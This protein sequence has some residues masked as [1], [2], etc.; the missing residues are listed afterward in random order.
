MTNPST[1]ATSG[2]TIGA[3]R[4]QRKRG[5]YPGS[6]NPPTIAHLAIAEAARRQ[7]DL[8]TV[9]LCVS[10]SALAKADV[11]H[12]RF[13]HRIE[14]LRRSVAA[15]DWL[16]VR[17]TELQLLADIANGY[18][19]LVMGADKWVQIQDPVWYNNNP[20]DRDAALARL[21]TP[22][23]APRDG[24][25]VPDDLALDVDPAL[26][27]RVSSTMARAGDT[28]VMLEPAQVFAA[29]TGAWVDPDRYERWLT[30]G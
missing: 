12:P 19:V 18:D 1:K 20:L 30:T 6:F 15:V 10:T 23:I 26:I 5:V 27:S 28:S 2:T 25:P 24:L 7:H 14:I 21:P 9:E 3:E 17:T 8:Q 11:V 29:E 4:P 13:D 16:T 22:A